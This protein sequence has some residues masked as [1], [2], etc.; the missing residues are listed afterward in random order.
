ME[1]QFVDSSQL[2]PTI[3]PGSSHRVRLHRLSQNPPIYRRLLQSIGIKPTPFWNSTSK[4]DYRLMPLLDPIGYRICKK[5][6]YQGFLNWH[7]QSKNINFIP[8]FDVYQHAKN[9]QDPFVNSGDTNDQWI[10]QCWSEVP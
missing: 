1:S 5:S 9:Q 3:Q 4:V 7:N 6:T 2:D 8:F 10:F